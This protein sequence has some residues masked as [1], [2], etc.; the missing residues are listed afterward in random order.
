MQR[1]DVR[2]AEVNS[3]PYAH[4]I[5]RLSILEKTNTVFAVTELRKWSDSTDLCNRSITIILA[6]EPRKWCFP[7]WLYLERY[8]DKRPDVW[9]RKNR[10][11]WGGNPHNY[12]LEPA[13]SSTRLMTAGGT[14]MVKKSRRSICLGF[15]EDIA[16]CLGEQPPSGCWSKKSPCLGL[17]ED[18]ANASMGVDGVVSLSILNFEK[19]RPELQ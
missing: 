7:R 12:A 4:L 9:L 1:E 10:Q 6:P 19:S 2:M 16:K 11:F 3:A 18:V 8:R 17:N 5:P 15:N 14:R 13:R